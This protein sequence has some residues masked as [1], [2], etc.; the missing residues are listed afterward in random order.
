MSFLYPWMFWAFAALLIPIAV[1]L[2]HF[3]RHKLL[4]FSNTAI[5]KTIQQEDA[6]TKKLKELVVLILRCVFIAALVIAFAFPYRTDDS[7]AA[8]FEDTMVGIYIDNSMSMKAPS[9]K[10]TLVEDA[11]QSA[12]ELVRQLSPSNRYLLM[13]N[14]FEVQN[15]YPMSQD[16]MM[17][18]LDRMSVDGPPVPMNEVLDRFSML[19]QRHGYEK[20]TFFVYSDFQNTTFDL[21]GV[22]SDSLMRL[23]LIP[24]TSESL[25]NISVDSVWLASP[26]VQEGLVNDVCIRVRNQGDKAVKGL[27]VTF[28]I[29]GHTEATTTV[30]VEAGKS[31]D[32]AMQFTVANSEDALCSVSL[33]DYPITFDD[34]YD[35]V[36]SPCSKLN[37]VEITAERDVTD[38]GLL[39]GDDPQFEYRKMDPMMVDRGLLTEAHLVAVN[40]S[41]SIQTTLKQDLRDLAA[42]G[43]SV[44]FFLDEGPVDTN[45]T[46]VSDVTVRH[47]FFEDIIVDMPEHADLP[48]VMQHVTQHPSSTTTTLLTLANGEPFMMVEPVGRGRVYTFSSLLDED[49][50]TLSD[51][52]LFVPLMLKMAFL[53]GGVDRISYTIGQDRTLVLNGEAAMGDRQIVIRNEDNSFEMMPAQ[54]QRGNRRLISLFDVLPSAGFYV[55]ADNDTIWAWTAWNDSRLESE[56]SFVEEGQLDDRF[57]KADFRHVTI[58]KPDDFESH[59]IVQAMLRK[60]TLWRNWL[61]LAIL[62]LLAEVAVLRF[63]K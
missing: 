7:V 15:E 28:S 50:C 35:F 45:R 13:T 3:R 58:L 42:E 10:T 14:S 46:M 24:M 40:G 54:Q 26:V 17:E 61:L 36:L 16:E 22:Q 49:W 18:Q 31:T 4:Y 30:D 25:S 39:F 47:E 6:K 38:L 63:W 44:V 32:A 59:D 29:N 12:K 34:R 48:K 5:L 2:F 43:A 62:A 53:G 20:S 21:D 9:T 27:P 8:S 33:M 41:S 52:T 51:N 37:V 19:R 55:L 23:I 57:S 60:S 56:M 1:H 11:R